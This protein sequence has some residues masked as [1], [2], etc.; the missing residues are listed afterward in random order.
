[1]NWL[2]FHHR[3]VV[4]QLKIRLTSRFGREYFPSIYMHIFPQ[5]RSYLQQLAYGG[6]CNFWTAR[7]SNFC[8]PSVFNVS[9]RDDPIK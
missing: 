7:G 8:C 9:E 5:T 1:M 4:I 3:F 6:L 2:A